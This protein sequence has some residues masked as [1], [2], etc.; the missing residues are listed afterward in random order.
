MSAHPT[1]PVPSSSGAIS[2]CEGSAK[3]RIASGA[4]LWLMGGVWVA[5][6]ACMSTD[7]SAP[8][9]NALHIGAVLP[10][11]GERAASGV[12]LEAALRLAIED[13]NAA[14][15]LGGRPL[16]L[17]VA[18]SHSD[19][20]RG[21]ANALKLIEDNAL[22]FFVGTEEPAI[23]Y[24][25]TSAVKVHGMVHLMPALTSARFHDPNAGAAWFRLSPSVTYIACSLGKHILAEGRTKPLVVVDA[26]DYSRFF[27]VKLGSVFRIKG[28]SALP[29][30]V[31]DPGSSS[32]TQ[33]F[34]TILRLAPDAVVVMTSPA[35]AAGLLQEWVAR[36][37]PIKIYLGPTLRDPEL[38]RNVPTGILEGVNGVSP[39]LGERAPAFAVYHE[40][41]TT[42]PPV[43][44]SHYY[45]DAAALL[46]LA[47]AEGFAQEGSIP[48]PPAMK[49]HMLNVTSETGIV[50][51][52][53]Q[54]AEG[55]ALLAAGQK[56]SYRGAAGS[57]VL[58]ANGD[59]TLS[60]G[61]IWQIVGNDF[62]TI[63]Y[64]QCDGTDVDTTDEQ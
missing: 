13:V 42:I 12:P 27:A 3:R 38:L 60:R 7:Q 36:G 6:A 8:P 19:D 55:F 26:D 24:Q 61:V 34:E 11:S 22:P 52:F 50:V 41:R 31:V 63:A 17:D 30:L 43:A 25:I 4:C 35:V 39:D 10:F 2:V 20:L 14:G 21:T 1:S 16:W 28:Y 5:M 51:A 29:T 45:F 54:L 47:A 18:D 9:A 58:N 57:Y 53:N 59:S 46:S 44:G 62:V 48:T 37:R 40:T 15:G 64:G 56:I 33:S 23:A 32:Y 49:P